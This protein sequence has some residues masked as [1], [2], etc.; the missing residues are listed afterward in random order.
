MITLLKAQ[1][2]QAPA[3]MGVHVVREWLQMMAL[4][5]IDGAG[6]ADRLAF[7]GGTALRILYQINRYSEDLDFCLLQPDDP[8]DVDQLADTLTTRL[9]QHG[10]LATC[11]AKGDRTVAVVWL[12][13]PGLLHQLGLSVH[14][15]Q[16][17]S[18]KLEI[19][20][21]PPK[22]YEIE[23]TILS[24][25]V[26]VVIQHHAKSSLYAGKCHAIL[27]RR[28]TKGRDFYDLIWYLGQRLTP[29]LTLLNAALAQTST[30]K[31]PLD[32]SSLKDALIYR[33]TQADMA[34]VWRDVG[35]FLMDPNDKRLFDQ[36]LICKMIQTAPF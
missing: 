7:V 26:M 11:Q 5:V 17:M 14:Q 13:F 28:Y 21:Q 31:G 18:I 35:P 4:H 25:P 29:N 23:R 32:G 22:G 10:L 16:V 3:E 9:A 30:A 20:Q 1:L 34:A 6:A 8:I 2:D 12:K 19:D 27:A 36:D 33:V 24:T 15:N